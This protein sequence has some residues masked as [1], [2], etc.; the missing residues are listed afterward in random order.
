MSAAAGGA[1]LVATMITYP[2]EVVR[3]RLRQPPSPNC[4]PRY[5]SLM[6]TFKLVLLEEGWGSLYGGLTP[7]LLRVLPNAIVM[8][9]VYEKILRLSAANTVV[10][11][12]RD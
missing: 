3:T 9:F 5:I 2:H 10:A 11:E 12:A 4:A 8:Y 1:K 6:Q 7:H